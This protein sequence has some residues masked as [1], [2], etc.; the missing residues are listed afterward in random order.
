MA[1]QNPFGRNCTKNKGLNDARTAEDY[2]HR[3]AYKQSKA[4]N[5][6]KDI[7]VGE[8]GLRRVKRG[9]WDE[10]D[11]MKMMDKA[12]VRPVDRALFDLE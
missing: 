1:G 5:E 11:F 9:E 8:A 2:Q 6:R 12:L 3:R 4:D 10:A 7:L